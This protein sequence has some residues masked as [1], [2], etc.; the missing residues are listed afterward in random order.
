VILVDSGALVA[1]AN[2]RDNHHEACARLLLTHAGPLLVPAT[3]VT[4]VSQL[5]EKRRGSKA[6][7]AFLKSFRSGLT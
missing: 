6:E 7:A 1:A 3:A 2:S 4:E 5:V